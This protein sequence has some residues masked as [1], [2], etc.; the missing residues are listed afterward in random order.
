MV[1]MSQYTHIYININTLTQKQKHQYKQKY[2][3]KQK[4]SSCNPSQQLEKAPEG[5]NYFISVSKRT[6][7]MLGK[8]LTQYKV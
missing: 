7:L 4:Q 1:I 3:N 5:G 8:G 2:R 6:G